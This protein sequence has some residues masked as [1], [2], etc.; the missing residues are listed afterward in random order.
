MFVGDDA[1]EEI[2]PY[3][4]RWLKYGFKKTN[5]MRE[6]AGFPGENP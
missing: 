6:S 2:F 3:I 5:W 4:Y 1:M